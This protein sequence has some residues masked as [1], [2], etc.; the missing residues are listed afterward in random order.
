VILVRRPLVG[1]TLCYMIGLLLGRVAPADHQLLLSL[2]LGLLALVLAMHWVQASSRQFLCNGLLL[3]VVIVV[4]WVRIGESPALPLDQVLAER[5]ARPVQLVGVVDGDP[6]PQRGSKGQGYRFPLRVERVI[7]EG[8]DDR[9]VEGRVQVLWYGFLRYGESPAYGERW[10]LGGALRPRRYASRSGSWLLVSRRDRATRLARGPKARVV[11]FC[12]A[13]RHQAAETLRVGIEDYPETVGLVHALLLGYRSEL[14]PAAH[15]LFVR[16]GT[17]HIF[18]VS[19]LHVGIVV[20][21]IVFALAA[22]SVPRRNWLLFVAPLLLAY[23]LMTGMKPSAVRACIMAM[24][25]LG[26]TALHRRADS[27]SSLAFAALALLAWSPAILM[28]ASFVLS[29]SVVTG[30]LLVFP[31]VEAMLR[32]LWAPDP[33]LAEPEQRRVRLGRWCGSKTAAMAAVSI[34]AWLISAPLIGA[35]FGRVAP[36]AVV[37]NIV[38][39]PMAF[40]IVLAGSLSIVFG[41]LVGVVAEIFNHAAL[42]LSSLLLEGL[43][44]LVMLPGGFVQ[45]PYMPWWFMA[46][47]YGLIVAA[48]LLL[49]AHRPP[50]P[51]VVTGEE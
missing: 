3:A 19:G 45:V 1:L 47:W 27:Y 32:P 28:E 31:H 36:I 43:R 20:G 48:L 38:V 22:C 26:A 7:F 49:Y 33:F 24:V 29:F 2:G 15:R 39:V 6:V 51:V 8:A 5:L 23:T 41:S 4:G 21:L 18:A 12:L 25:F 44:M 16:S 9:A 11:Q 40:L 46:T 35:Y 13:L 30:I 10:R 34:S 37:A 14:S 17:L 50:R 42:A